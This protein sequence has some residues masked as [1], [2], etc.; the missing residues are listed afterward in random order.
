M[1]LFN[2]MAAVLLLIVI[3][4]LSSEKAIPTSMA[5]DRQLNYDF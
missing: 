4:V 3:T 5:N 1:E 2:A